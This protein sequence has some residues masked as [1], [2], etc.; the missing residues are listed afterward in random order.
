MLLTLWFY[1]WLVVLT[2]AIGLLAVVLALLD[3]SGHQA[4]QAGRWWART[5]LKIAKVS[6]TIHGLEH[7]AP[8]RAYV[9]AA[10]HKSEFDIFVLQAYLPGQF[11]W[12]AKIEL[13]Y[14]PI[15]G[16]ALRLTGSL[17]I[18][19]R[20]RQAAIRSLNQAADKVQS[21]TSIIIFPEG[22]RGTAGQLLPFKKGGFVLAIKSGQPLV[23]VSISGTRFIQARGMF[24]IHPGPVKVVLGHPIE[25]RAYTLNRK[26]ELMVELQAAIEQNY[27]PDYPYGPR[28][29]KVRG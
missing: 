17:P 11:R 14:I 12:L 10:N 9:F 16:H 21:G 5:L 13:F 20:N 24:R 18:D 19:R 2:V 1:F 22:T 23:P 25:T 15:F 7:L 4:H 3:P 6:V 29:G 8:G 28:R 26:Q 27:D